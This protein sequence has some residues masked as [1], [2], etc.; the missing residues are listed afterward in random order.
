MISLE[1]LKEYKNDEVVYRFTKMFDIPIEESNIVFEELKKWL[2]VCANAKKDRAKNKENV[3]E[4]IVIDNSLLVI[5]E[6]W[7]NFICFTK[8][9]SDFC[10][11]ILG[12]FIHHFPTPKSFNDQ[13]KEKIIQDPTYQRKRREIQYE[14]IYDLL[15]AE[16][17]ELWYEKFADKYTAKYMF[18]KRLK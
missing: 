4:R 17:L 8:D 14:Y 18:E 12:T 10:N 2:W 15:G 7:H 6:M 3:P 1:K 9:Y 13:L 16:T 11:N 5:D